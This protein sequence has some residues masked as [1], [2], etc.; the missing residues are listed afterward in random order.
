MRV[1][2]VLIIAPVAPTGRLKEIPDPF[3]FTFSG[4][5]SNCC[6]TAQACAANA[7]FDSM[8]SRS[9]TLSPARFRDKSA[10]SF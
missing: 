2:F 8:T 10:P 9:R 7:S 4:S 5:R 3:G 1:A 6:I